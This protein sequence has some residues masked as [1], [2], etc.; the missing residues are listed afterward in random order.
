MICGMVDRVS[1]YSGN[2][3]SVT[4]YA[5][6]YFRRQRVFMTE[7]KDCVEVLAA[8]FAFNI[9]L[10]DTQG[11]GYDRILAFNNPIL[12]PGRPVVVAT[13]VMRQLLL[14]SDLQ[15]DLDETDEAEAA[16][17]NLA[18]NGLGL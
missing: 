11:N 10:N 14:L 17:L 6:E 3:C 18:F 5:A 9:K 8:V 7:I 2:D 13:F 12:N 16:G 1:M 4:Q 15:A